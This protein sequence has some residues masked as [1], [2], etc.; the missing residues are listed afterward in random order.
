M[1]AYRADQA[2]SSHDYELA[3][4]QIT[5]Y[6]E[7]DLDTIDGI[8]QQTEVLG[9]LSP[10]CASPVED[11]GGLMGHSPITALKQL[12]G[13]LT[14]MLMEE[15]D[16]AVSNDSSEDMITCFKIFPKIAKGSLGLDKFSAYISSKVS[17]HCKQA[18]K[19]ALENSIY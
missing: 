13:V 15:F 11:L 16:Q 6:L 2:V 7:F 4:F 10:V 19:Q 12:H 1:C 14:G 17:N 18:M 9:S 5:R 3:S 8:Y